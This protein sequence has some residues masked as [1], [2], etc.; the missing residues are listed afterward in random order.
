VVYT[1]SD[2]G[3]FLLKCQAETAFRTP[4]S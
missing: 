3:T 2:R 4:D 1:F